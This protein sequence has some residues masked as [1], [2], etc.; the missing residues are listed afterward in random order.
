MEMV[1]EFPL[2][3]IEKFTLIEDDYVLEFDFNNGKIQGLLELIENFS[4]S[5]PYYNKA[6]K[7]LIV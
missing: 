5:S 6:M 4:K 2:N 1:K 7:L 3:E